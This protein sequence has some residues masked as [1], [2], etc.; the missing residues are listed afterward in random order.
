MGHE[1]RT[2]CFVLPCGGFLYPC[3]VSSTASISVGHIE[4][5]RCLTPRLARP[6]ERDVD[7]ENGSHALWAA[8]LRSGPDMTASRPCG[9]RLCSA[10]W[11]VSTH[12]IFV[13]PRRATRHLGVRCR[14]PHCWLTSHQVPRTGGGACTPT[15]MP[16]VGG[17]GGSSSVWRLFFICRAPGASA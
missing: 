16:E 14:A 8:H 11:V 10:H 4:I 13:E 3:R 1:S 17:G 7:A 5:V 9:D 12:G 2:G 6:K 15:R